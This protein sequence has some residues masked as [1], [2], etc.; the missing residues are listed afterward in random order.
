M[1]II[2]RAVDICID[3]RDR[4]GNKFWS[5]R[6][7]SLPSRPAVP[8]GG[9]GRVGLASGRRGSGG[10]GGGGGVGGPRAQLA[11]D[12][13]GRGRLHAGLVVVLPAVL[14]V[15]CEAGLADYAGPGGGESPPGPH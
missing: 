6:Q 2:A 11:G 4:A 13:G 7:K 5:F 1:T 10:G 15:R 8:G 9:R 14:S 3:R 12:G